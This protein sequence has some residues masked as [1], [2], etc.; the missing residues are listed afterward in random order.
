MIPDIIDSKP[1]PI[2]IQ[3]QNRNAHMPVTNESEYFENDFL[4]LKILISSDKE[5]KKYNINVQN[6]DVRIR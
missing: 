5:I 6:V 4:F 3:I 1:T 2:I